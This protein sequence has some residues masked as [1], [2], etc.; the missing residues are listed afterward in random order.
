MSVNNNNAG[1]WFN[2]PDAHQG[3]WVP[4]SAF[5]NVASNNVVT[6]PNKKFP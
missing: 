3:Y 4:F 1:M 2:D 5:Q 6:N